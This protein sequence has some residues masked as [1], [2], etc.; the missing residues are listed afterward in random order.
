MSLG[1]HCVARIRSPR[2]PL[3]DRGACVSL[4]KRLRRRFPKV[5]ACILMPNHFHLLVLEADPLAL[6]WQLGV[7]VRA[8]SRSHFPKNAM[9]EPVPQPTPIHDLLHLRRQIRYVQLNPC[10]AHWVS[11]PL[12]WEWSTHRD[13]TGAVAD[14]WLD[15]ATLLRCFRTTDARLGD[16]A[17]QY[18]AADPTVAVEGTAGLANFRSGGCTSAGAESLL[19]VAAIVS[20]SHH[21]IL[22]G[23]T[24][25]LAIHLSDRLNLKPEPKKL[26]ITANA[27]RRALQRPRAQEAL[28]AAL[29]VL[30]DPRCLTDSA[31]LNARL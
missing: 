19:R 29:R 31:G 9:W 20:R 30:S 22:R 26:G 17:H 12:A 13:L 11:D 7:E 6:R 28:R 8:W 15:R 23:P 5:A 14:P 10:R 2:T 3:L 16:V 24:R 27:W 21:E 18:I 1:F 4:W 25:D